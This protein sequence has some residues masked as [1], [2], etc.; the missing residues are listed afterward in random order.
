[1]LV[2]GCRS[3]GRQLNELLSRVTCPDI[4]VS[5]SHTMLATGPWAH[6]LQSRRGKA[7]RG[8]EWRRQPRYALI[9]MFLSIKSGHVARRKSPAQEQSSTSSCYCCC[10]CPGWLPVVLTDSTTL[11]SPLLCPPSRSVVVLPWCLVPLLVLVLFLVLALV[12]ALSW[13]LSFVGH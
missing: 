8:V 1:M 7:R 10:C 6:G 4:L 11:L 9:F 13:L 2:A 3:M 5:Q 12:L